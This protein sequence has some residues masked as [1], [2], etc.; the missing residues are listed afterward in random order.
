VTQA[1]RDVG[2]LWENA[3]LAHLRQAALEPIDRNFTCRYGEIDLIMHDKSARGQAG[4]VFV[5]VRYR[6]ANARGDGVASV[7]AGKRAK[8]IRAAAVYL[9]THPRF[10]GMPCRFD[11]IACSG[12]P[13]NPHFDW[14]RA[15]FDAH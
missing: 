1:T 7:G 10:D 14:I 8:L 3:A 12:T 4:V 11:V 15:A 2:T 13:D 5:E 9:Q 6:N